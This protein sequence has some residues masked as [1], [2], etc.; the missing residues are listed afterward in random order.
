MGFRQ[1]LF[2]LRYLQYIQLL[3]VVVGGMGLLSCAT[4]TAS[5]FT[6]PPPP[7]SIPTT[8]FGMH[9]NQDDAPWPVVAVGAQRL[10]DSGANWAEIETSPGNYDF[11]KIDKLMAQA[12]AHGV[13]LL[14]TF[15]DVPQFHSSNPADTTC[16]YPQN[17]NGGCDPPTDLNS[18][19]T[20]T[21]RSFKNFVTALA[22]HV[23]SKIAYW[24]VWNEP[25]A[26][27]MWKGTPQQLVRMAQDAT[28]IIK[29][30]GS[31]C[32]ASATN[33]NAQMLTPAPT[34]GPNSVTQWMSTYLAAGGGQYAD[35]I[36]FHGYVQCPDTNVC[37]LTPTPEVVTSTISNLRSMLSSNGQGQKPLFDSEGS[38]GS[39][40]IVS[41]N[42][43]DLRSAFVARY[44]VLQQSAGIERLYWYRWDVGGSGF[45]GTLWD[46]VNT[47]VEGCNFAG[48]PY[49]G[50][51]LCK[52]G[53]AYAQVYNWLVGANLSTPCASSGTVWSCGY[54]R[55]NGYQAQIVWDTSQSCRAGVCTTSS[56]S[57]AAQYKQYRDLGGN[58]TTINGNVPIGAKP[59]ILETGTP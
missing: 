24:E 47:N 30:T 12:Q 21:N 22:S 3:A 10:H 15:V 52:P 17:G 35:V 36:S 7:G 59:V 1:Y 9:I 5:H 54:T 25:D 40:D 41:F 13:D 23:G 26:D 39:G 56:Y 4:G 18:D 20:G 33:A 38:W 16:A 49:Q 31:G 11:T 46:T 6:Q 57:A 42:N 28:C 55:P 8:F 51:F 37:P 29:G 43:P 27:R 34:G 44:I 50:G 45:W 53:T 2:R 58:T 48:S 14:Y 19:G 32:T